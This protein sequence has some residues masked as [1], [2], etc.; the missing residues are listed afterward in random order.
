MQDEQY[1]TSLIRATRKRLVCEVY[2]EAHVYF[3]SCMLHLHQMKFSVWRF[4]RDDPGCSQWGSKDCQFLTQKP[5]PPTPKRLV[6]E[7]FWAR[8]DQYSVKILQQTRQN[9]L[10]GHSRK[11]QALYETSYFNFKFKTDLYLSPT[12]L[13]PC[14]M[15]NFCVH[16]CYLEMQS[17]HHHPFYKW[18]STD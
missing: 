9:I 6:L 10:C 13:M 16:I 8:L 15:V 18:R 14:T 1:Y 3:L 4:P 5:W 12:L 11:H 7:W 2:Q 17:R